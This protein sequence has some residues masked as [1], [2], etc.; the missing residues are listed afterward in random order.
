ME[1]T[2]VSM[3]LAQFEEMRAKA[4]NYDMIRQGVE[5][6][7]IWI[8]TNSKVNVDWNSFIKEYNNTNPEHP[9]RV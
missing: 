3:P 9:F 1:E 2:T 8:Q 5:G 7:M 4:D 6:F